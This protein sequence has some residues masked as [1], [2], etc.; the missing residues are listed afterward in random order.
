MFKVNNNIPEE[1]HLTSFQSFNV[2]FEHISHI[3]LTYYIVSVVILNRY[4]RIGLIHRINVPCKIQISENAVTVP[5]PESEE[6]W[7]RTISSESK[8]TYIQKLK[9]KSIC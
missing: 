4:M 2:N 3:T 8:V 5:A 6:G 7:F 9:D 1:E